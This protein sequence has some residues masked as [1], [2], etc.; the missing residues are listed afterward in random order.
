MTGE[1]QIVSPIQPSVVAKEQIF[2][3]DQR[4]AFQILGLT[5]KD[6]GRYQR[7]TPEKKTRSEK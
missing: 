2:E 4:L 3:K 6:P 5:V 7:D 1:R